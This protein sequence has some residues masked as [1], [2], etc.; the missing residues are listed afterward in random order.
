M[1]LGAIIEIQDRKDYEYDPVWQDPLASDHCQ[2]CVGCKLRINS[3]MRVINF[4]E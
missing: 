2:I 3:N 1:S 4:N